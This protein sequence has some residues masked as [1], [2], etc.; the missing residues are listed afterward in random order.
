MESTYSMSREEMT[1]FLS[2]AG[3][4]NHN[5]EGVRFEYILKSGEKVLTHALDLQQIKGLKCTSVR[6][7]VFPVI[8]GKF[9][10]DLAYDICTANLGGE[11]RKV[12]FAFNSSIF[13]ARNL[14]DSATAKEVYRNSFE[15]MCEV[16]RRHRGLWQ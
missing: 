6:I 1:E 14:P 16:Q 15:L 8:H 5:R 2:R 7:K 10:E 11:C 3:T 13:P 9:R 12:S 4:V